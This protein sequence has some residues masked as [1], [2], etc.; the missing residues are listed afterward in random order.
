MVHKL[1]EMMF[2]KLIKGK[3]NCLNGHNSGGS[4]FGWFA[5]S[6]SHTSFFS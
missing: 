6:L 1:Q 3:N 2:R 5:T 4:S